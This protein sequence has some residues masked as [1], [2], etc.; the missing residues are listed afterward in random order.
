MGLDFTVG[1]DEGP[2]AM[3][4]RPAGMACFRGQSGV[5]RRRR[6]GP[7]AGRPPRRAAGLEQLGRLTLK[8]RPNTSFMANNVAAMPP[9]RP[10]ISAG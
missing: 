7:W 10:G 3:A 5:G 1:A 2:W 6:T 8:I 4:R 9:D